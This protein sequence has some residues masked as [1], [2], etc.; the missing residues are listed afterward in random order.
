MGQAVGGIGIEQDEDVRGHH[1]VLGERHLAAAVEVGYRQMI[2]GDGGGRGKRA[3]GTECD[4]GRGRK[5]RFIFGLL[6]CRGI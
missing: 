4:E 2:G 5:G 6:T 1:P 3:A